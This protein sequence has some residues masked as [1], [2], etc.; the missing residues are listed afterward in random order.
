MGRRC[1]CFA[2]GCKGTPGWTGPLVSFP[3]TGAASRRGSRCQQV[4]SLLP[5]ALLPENPS[6]W[7]RRG[8]GAP[9]AA[10]Q[11]PRA[12]ARPPRATARGLAPAALGW[13]HVLIPSTALLW[14]PAQDSTVSSAVS[15]HCLCND[16]VN[17]RNHSAESKVSGL[18]M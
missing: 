9:P 11:Q 2:H 5:R 10:R 12:G 13:G 4:C 1:T 14:F 3:V 17:A 6:L 7:Q 8:L 16:V 18:F 15:L